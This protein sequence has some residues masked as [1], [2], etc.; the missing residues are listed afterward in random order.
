M[1]I[2]IRWMERTK[3]VRAICPRRGGVLSSILSGGEHGCEAA[4]AISTA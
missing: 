3:K 2:P 4:L 1:I